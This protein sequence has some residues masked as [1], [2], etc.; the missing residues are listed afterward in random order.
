MV[1]NFI[2]ENDK[3]RLVVVK[4][5]NLDAP[6]MVGT[7]VRIKHRLHTII[8]VILEANTVEYNVLIK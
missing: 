6:P 5:L 4:S 1:V 8:A 2:K 7:C 3:G